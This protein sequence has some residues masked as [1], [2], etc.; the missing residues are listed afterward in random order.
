MQLERILHS[1]GFGSRKICRSLIRHGEVSVNG[2]V[3]DFPFTEFD[4]D[5]FTFTVRGEDWQFREK[6]Y[7]MINKPAHYEC[8]HKPQHHPSVFSLL[9]AP[10]LERGVQ[11]VGRLDEDTTGLLLLSDDGQFIHRMSSP[12]WKAPKVYQVTAKHPL[13]EAQVQALLQGVQL[14]DEPA[15]V[16]ALA[17][18][19]VSEHVLH[20]TLAEGK[21]HQVKRML[22]AVSNR[23]E[24]LK[25]IRIGNLDLPE[26]LAAGEWRWLDAE[27]L[28]AVLPVRQP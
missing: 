17:A 3:H 23:V 18:E 7:L 11:C 12:K 20:L 10:L 5:N 16:A 1:Q 25:R 27:M 26:D 15:P 2:E 4:T 14:L 19:V 6:A 22:A 28:E 21:Y 9:P 24:A 8:S 13:E